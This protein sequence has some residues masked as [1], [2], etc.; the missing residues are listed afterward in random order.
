MCYECVTSVLQ[1][2]YKCVAS[3]LGVCCEC[4]TGVSSEQFQNMFDMNL[5]DLFL[6]G[7]L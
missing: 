4:V 3:M 2:C 1:G 7:N 6:K 5:S